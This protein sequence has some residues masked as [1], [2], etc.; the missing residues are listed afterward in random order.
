M[1]LTSAPRMWVGLNYP[2]NLIIWPVF[3]I[4]LLMYLG[5]NY[6]ANLIIWP[7]FMIHLLMYL[8]PNYLANLII[9]PVFMIHCFFEVEITVPSPF[10]LR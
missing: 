4:H 6:P 9:W 5:P 1:T 10:I 8:G 3:M 2:A 7:V